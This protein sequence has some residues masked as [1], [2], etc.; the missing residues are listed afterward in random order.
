MVITGA[1]RGSALSSV[2]LSRLC[3]LLTVMG[4][5][6]LICSLIWLPSDGVIFHADS[7][8]STAKQND[9]AGP[10]WAQGPAFHPLF[11][12]TGVFFLF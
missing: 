1:R 3:L 4:V 9:R 7:A 6:D 12:S 8:S 5:S 2:M 11:C 10:A